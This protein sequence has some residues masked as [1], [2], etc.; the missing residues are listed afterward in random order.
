MNRVTKDMIIRDIIVMD[1]SL[2]PILMASGMH[3]ITCGAAMFETL[4]EACYVHAIDADQLVNR[5]NEY[6][7][8]KEQ[9]ENGAEA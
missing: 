3:C 2:V 7:E 1:T 4:E 6:L 9:A 8:E 5:M